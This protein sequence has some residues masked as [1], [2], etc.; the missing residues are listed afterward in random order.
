M[1]GVRQQEKFLSSTINK[2]NLVNRQ[3]G[4]PSVL[5]MKKIA[6][7]T[8][9]TGLTGLTGLTGPT[10]PTGASKMLENVRRAKKAAALIAAARK[11]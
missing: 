1:F 5:T 9:P 3:T 2:F 6:G 4:K 10:G 8:G 7:P 11:R